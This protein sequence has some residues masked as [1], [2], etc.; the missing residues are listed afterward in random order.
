MVQGDRLPGTIYDRMHHRGSQAA[1]PPQGGCSSK[2]TEALQLR[3][4]VKEVS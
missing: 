1:L 3:Y 2:H 4:L